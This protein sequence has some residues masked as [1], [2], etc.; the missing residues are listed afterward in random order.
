VK[1]WICVLALFALPAAAEDNRQLAKLTP[2]ARETL[3][4]EMLDNLMA[5]N[6]VLALLAANKVKEAGDVAEKRLGVS[7][8]GKN[9][10]L[11]LDARPGPQMPEAMNNLGRS[12]HFAAS[13][14]AKAAASGDR[15][16]ALTELP[17]LTGT[18]VAC[19]AAYRTR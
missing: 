11:P 3:R 7:A 16:R 10:N 5:L 17:K 2:Q 1:K 15:G 19:H 13:E 6:E 9:A 4:Q 18:C 12:G 14:F 8:M